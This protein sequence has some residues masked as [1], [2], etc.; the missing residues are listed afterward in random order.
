[1][2]KMPERWLSKPTSKSHQSI[3][4]FHRWLLHLLF[5]IYWLGEERGRES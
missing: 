2:H 1:M 5:S 4:C 3:V